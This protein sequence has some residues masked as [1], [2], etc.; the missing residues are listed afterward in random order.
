MLLSVNSD[1]RILFLFL[2]CLWSGMSC[3]VEEEDNDGK[4]QKGFDMGLMVAGDRNFV[5]VT[6][7]QG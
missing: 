6:I 4:P 5:G 7:V 3:K 2:Y 1:A